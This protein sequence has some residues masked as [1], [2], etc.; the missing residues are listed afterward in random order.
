MGQEVRVATTM[1]CLRLDASGRNCG[2]R[3]T[4]IQWSD[5]TLHPTPL[6][7]AFCGHVA[8]QPGIAGELE[9]RWAATRMSLLIQTL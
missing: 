7:V 8:V 3:S 5:N 6:P 4:K 9:G 1:N 2:K